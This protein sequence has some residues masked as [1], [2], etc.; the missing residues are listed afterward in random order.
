MNLNKGEL[1]KR[2]VAIVEYKRDGYTYSEIAEMFQLSRETIKLICHQ[3]GVYGP[4][5]PR[6]LREKQPSLFD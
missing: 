6:R 1:K 2:N 3:A 4:S 5:K